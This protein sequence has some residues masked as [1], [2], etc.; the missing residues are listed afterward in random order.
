MSLF[1]EKYDVKFLTRQRGHG[2]GFN[3]RPFLFIFGSGPGSDFI[4]FESGT[5]FYPCSRI[6]GRILSMVSPGLSPDF[7][8]D[9]TKNG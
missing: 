4:H 6:Q 2:R 9:K 8:M 7:V 5:G 1:R 3:T